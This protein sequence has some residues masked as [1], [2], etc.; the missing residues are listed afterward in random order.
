MTEES[1]VEEVPVSSKKDVSTTEKLKV[2]EVTEEP[3]TDKV[4][5][6]QEKESKVD[7]VMKESKV[8]DTASTEEFKE[9]IS[10]NEQPKTDKDLL[11]EEDSDMIVSEV[12]EKL[13]ND[14]DT[15]LYESKPEEISLVHDT[16]KIQES[17][18][19]IEDLD[20]V[21]YT[22]LTLPTILLV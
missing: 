5:S 12:L 6:L 11:Q 22:H 1:K 18:I 20:P 13:V 7:V 15:E 14:V 17:V 16:L 8:E 9:E 2:E 21:S 3:R 19:K 4:E 10:V